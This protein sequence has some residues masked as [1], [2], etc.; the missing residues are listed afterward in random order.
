MRM[1]SILG[2]IL[3]SFITQ[4]DARE[5]A[6]D[7]VEKLLERKV[8]L[9]PSSRAGLDRTALAKPGHLSITPAKGT[10]PQI[11]S[12]AIAPSRLK[13]LALRTSGCGVGVGIACGAGTRES[14]SSQTGDEGIGQ[15][16]GRRD[17]GLTALFGSIAA[18]AAQPPMVFA[19][20]S[21]TAEG[22]VD[23]PEGMKYQDVRVGKR[24]V[25]VKGDK[26]KVDFFVYDYSMGLK[27]EGGGKPIVFT[28]GEEALAKG[29]DLAI[30]GGGEMPPMQE[31]GQ[32]KV[33][34]PPKLTKEGGSLTYEI[35]IDLKK[36]N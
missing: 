34:V 20:S 21:F 36:V 16:L 24:K 14:S 10:R 31:G 3:L 22:F 25:P 33:V 26:V 4:G 35:Y 13:G 5:Y 32:R 9:S 1:W 17:A 6:E 12:G 8:E 29:W 30:L 19:D 15:L 7:S 27:L 2:I 18:I 23:G 11:V 28:V